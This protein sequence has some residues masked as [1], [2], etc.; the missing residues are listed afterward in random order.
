MLLPFQLFLQHSSFSLYKAPPFFHLLSA[1][2]AFAARPPHTLPLSSALPDMKASTQS[3]IHLQNLYKDQAD[4]EKTVFKSLISPDV[5]IS[6]D[7]ID[8]FVKNVHGIKVIRG[9]CWN[10]LDEDATALGQFYTSSLK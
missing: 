8:A 1:L 3:Y 6:D 5:A 9:S 7:V 10:A 4:Q 2:K